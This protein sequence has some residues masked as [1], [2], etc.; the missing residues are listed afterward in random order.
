[1]TRPNVKDLPSLLEADENRVKYVYKDSIGFWT[2]G[3]GILVDRAKGGGLRDEEIDF[4]LKNRIALNKAA[5][6]K[7]LPWFNT[8]D[9]CRQGVLQSMAFQL[10]IDGLMGFK[11][12]LDMVR[13]GAY[14][15]AAANMLQSLWAK[16]TPERAQ[17]LATQMKTG[18]WQ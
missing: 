14:A 8:L 2:I 6:T 11:N 5:L 18:V 17:R 9:E 1:M 16:Q 12:T 13:R 10:G 3:I 4:I 7:Q 15:D